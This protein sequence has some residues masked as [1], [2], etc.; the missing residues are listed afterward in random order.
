LQRIQMPLP[1]YIRGVY[2]L[3]AWL[4]HIA[5][6]SYCSGADAGFIVTGG[7][8]G[9]TNGQ[10]SPLSGACTVD[11]KSGNAINSCGATYAGAAPGNFPPGTTATKEYGQKKAC[12]RRAGLNPSFG[13]VEET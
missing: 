6:A 11:F 7:I 2:E 8:N 1:V 10:V 12:S 3:Q 9:G 13:R 5:F 4:G